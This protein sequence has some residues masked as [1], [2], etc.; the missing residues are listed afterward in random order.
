MKNKFLTLSVAAVALGACSVLFPASAH[1]QQAEVGSIYYLPTPSIYQIEPAAGG[2]VIGTQES[3]A[4]IEKDRRHWARFFEYEHREHCQGYVDPPKGWVY[5]RCHL[6]PAGAQVTE[7]TSTVTQIEPAAGPVA[8]DMR[9]VVVNFD[10]DRDNIRADQQQKVDEAA[11]NIVQSRANSVTIDGHADASGPN[12]YNMGLSERRA[13]TI[14][15]ALVAQ[16]VNPAIIAKNAHG[17]EDLAVPT[18]DGVR[19]EA[20][21]RVSIQYMPAAPAPGAMRGPGM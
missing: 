1:A 5:E 16:G 13:E 6:V 18:A 17:E 11:M 8:Y 10:W 12:D 15:N 9:S 19:L 21:R 7:T 3:R 2:A 20:N 14:A 4:P